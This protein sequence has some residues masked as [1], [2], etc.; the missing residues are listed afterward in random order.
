MGFSC[1]LDSA[2]H[3]RDCFGED[4]LLRFCFRGASSRT[5]VEGDCKRTW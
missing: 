1:S 5:G 4:K 2:R 3:K